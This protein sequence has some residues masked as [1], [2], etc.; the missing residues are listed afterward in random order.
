MKRVTKRW[1]QSDIEIL[2][3]NVEK[4][5]SE[6]SQLLGRSIRSIKHK[7]GQLG[8]KRGERKKW[9]DEEYEIL[10]KYSHLR[11]R[12][13]IEKGLIKGRSLEQVAARCRSVRGSALSVIKD[14]WRNES[15]DLAYLLG[16]WC[17]DGTAGEYSI[18]WSQKASDVDF[19]DKIRSCIRSVFKLEPKGNFLEGASYSR[20][21]LCSKGV[22]D[23]FKGVKPEW[24]DLCRRFP[25]LIDDKYWWHFVGGLFD[26][27]GSLVIQ[28]RK[29]TKNGTYKVVSFGIKPERSRKWFIDVMKEKGFVFTEEIY[30][31]STSS[32]WKAVLTGGTEKTDEFVQK[33][34]SVLM[35]KRRNNGNGFARTSLNVANEFLDQNHYLGG[36]KT[37]YAIG[38]FRNGVLVGVIMFSSPI[39]PIEQWRLLGKEY[40]SKVTELSRLCIS[41]SEG[42]NFASSLIAQGLKRIAE[43]GYWAVLSYTDTSVG[44]KGV[45]YKA[46]NAYCLG[47]SS[48][49][50]KLIF[51]YL[52]AKG[53]DRRIAKSAFFLN[54][55]SRMEPKQNAEYVL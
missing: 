2:T 37:G 30:N 28:F 51:A 27:D 11:P 24:V 13:F 35:R 49:N 22:A 5:Y 44:H 29:S 1:T 42:K 9:T 25:W 20:I 52:V 36:R 3:A 23:F 38:G 6:L 50:K 32:T 54:N 33:M 17:S 31:T 8:L 4:S 40:G 34:E 43:E 53:E 39:S 46:T 18:Q 21:W 12:D 10:K 15:T 41:S 55:R 16:A 14:D 7:V 47:R 26:G 48:D 45:V 19:V